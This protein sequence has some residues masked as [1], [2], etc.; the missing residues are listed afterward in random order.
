MYFQQITNHPQ[1]LFTC[2]MGRLIDGVASILGVKQINTYEGEAAMQLEALATKCSYP[3]YD[4][5]PIPIINGELDWQ[6]MLLGII[7][8]HL[9]GEPVEE[10]A[11]KFFYSLAHAIYQTSKHFDIRKLAFSG[12]VFQNKLLVDLIIEMMQ[13]KCLLYFH[14]QLS[15]NDECIA[16]GQLAHATNIK[17]Q[18]QPMY[19]ED[20]MY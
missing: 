7:D 16:F 13:H 19:E 14:Q 6:E 10:I 1:H 17:I 18:K 3:I 15:P 11:R 9:N 5:Y 8:D 4:Y 20:E 12:G 2:S